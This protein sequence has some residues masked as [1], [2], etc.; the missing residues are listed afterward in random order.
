MRYLVF[1]TF[2]W[3]RLIDY[4]IGDEK[5]WLNRVT[6]FDDSVHLNAIHDLTIPESVRCSCTDDVYQL[7]R[8]F[9]GDYAFDICLALNKEPKNT[10]RV[11]LIKTT[12]DE[13]LSTHLK[14][15]GVP[16]SHS[17]LGIHLIQKHHQLKQSIYEQ[18][19]FEWQDEASQLVAALVTPSHGDKILD[20][21]AG[22]GGKTLAIAS[23]LDQARFQFVLHD[24]R[25]SVK[26]RA[27][28][29][30]QKAG[31]VNWK[32]FLS[33][34]AELQEMKKTFDWVLVDAP[35]TGIGAWRR[36]PSLKWKVDLQYIEKYTSRQR[37]ILMK[38]SEYCRPEGRLVYATC[39][40]LPQENEYQI[41]WFCSSLGKGFIEKQ[42]RSD[43]A[44]DD[45]DGL[46]GSVICF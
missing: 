34:S 10:I 40:L 9:Y 35:C 15:I 31:V 29:R 38:A 7:L 20:F 42:F 22:A 43:P 6:A 44:K 25:E 24:I 3:K 45:M 27:E 32:Y 14:S 41:D 28:E 5:S 21:C 36:D 17:P 18:G 2:R 37:E 11:N 16:C 4:L 39:S 8:N 1:G 12:R 26:E 19:L 30:L 46:F 13:L 23:S 33:E